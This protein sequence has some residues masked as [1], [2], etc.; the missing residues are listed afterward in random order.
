MVSIERTGWPGPD[1]APAIFHEDT[2]PRNMSLS[3]RI[4][5]EL[6]I[7]GVCKSY[8]PYGK[9]H[10][11][12]TS[13]RTRVKTYSQQSGIS[14]PTSKQVV[15]QTQ[16]IR[17]WTHKTNRH[18]VQW[19]RTWPLRC[20]TSRVTVTICYVFRILSQ[21]LTIGNCLSRSSQMI[22]HA[23]RRVRPKIN[24]KTWHQVQVSMIGHKNWRQK[25]KFQEA[26]WPSSTS[27]RISKIRGSR[28]G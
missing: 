13:R 20:W 23:Y 19:V 7:L 6:A 22:S 14:R 18:L 26:L 8:L 10:K 2:T 21:R 25:F 4:R 24:N 28:K 17:N 27:L 1:T 11:L 12:G 9:G 16:T 15:T 3:Q 5:M